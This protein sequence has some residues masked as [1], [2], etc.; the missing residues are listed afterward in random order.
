MCSLTQADTHAL[1]VLNLV[2]WIDRNGI[3]AIEKVGIQMC[4]FSDRGDFWA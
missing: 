4:G 2:L 3:V 1:R